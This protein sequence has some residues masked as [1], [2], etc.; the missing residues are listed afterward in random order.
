MRPEELSQVQTAS[1]CQVLCVKKAPVITLVKRTH[2]SCKVLQQKTCDRAASITT[3]APG[4]DADIGHPLKEQETTTVAG[5][6]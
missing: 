3:S 6:H 4:E 1:Y 5:F 2:Q